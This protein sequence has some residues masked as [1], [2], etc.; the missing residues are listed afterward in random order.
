MLNGPTFVIRNVRDI[1]GTRRFYTDKLG[2]RVAAEQPGF[3]QF[4]ATGGAAYA[5]AAN[6]D[7]EATEVWWNVDDVDATEEQARARGVEIVQP[8]T[9]MPFGRTLVIRDAAGNNLYLLQPPA[10]A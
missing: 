6:P 1:D 2:F 4:A 5:L 3:V 9:N 8:P 10:G 7:G